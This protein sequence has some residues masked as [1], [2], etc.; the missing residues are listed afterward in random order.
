MIPEVRRRIRAKLAAYREWA[1]GRK[2]QRIARLVQYPDCAADPLGM[3][4]PLDE[5]EDQIEGLVA[6]GFQV[7][8]NARRGTVY[9]RVWERSDPEPDWPRVYAERPSTDPASE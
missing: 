9:L 7:D 5:V 2:F 6:E 3:D 8:W 1:T 4:V